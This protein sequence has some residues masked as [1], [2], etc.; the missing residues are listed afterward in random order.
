MTETARGLSERHTPAVGQSKAS[1]VDR[2]H[3][4]TAVLA[5]T[6]YPYVN[7]NCGFV[8]CKMALGWTR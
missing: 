5:N 4:E 1:L 8:V 2:G 7:S 6:V 3:N